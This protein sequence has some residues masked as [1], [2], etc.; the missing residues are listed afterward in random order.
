VTV[1]LLARGVMKT[2]RTGAV[3]GPA[4]RGVDLDSGAWLALVRRAPRGGLP[5]RLG[6][7]HPLARPFRRRCRWGCSRWYSPAWSS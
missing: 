6:L 3:E 1:V 4:L 2:Y 5:L 7:A